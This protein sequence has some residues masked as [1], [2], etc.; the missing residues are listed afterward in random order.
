MKKSLSTTLSFRKNLLVERVH[1]KKSKWSTIFFICSLVATLS[2]YAQTDTLIVRG[3]VENLTLKLYR[4]APEISVARVNILQSNQEIVRAAQLQPDGSFELKMPLIYPQEE[5]YL[6]Y[7]DVVMPF[8]GA[9][10]TVEVTILAD[11]LGKSEVPL[12]FGGLYATTNNRHAQFY[13][14]FNKWLKANP[15][16]PA[17]TDNLHRFWE[18]ASQEQNRRQAFYKSF[19][20][21]KDPLLDKWVISSLENTT[22]AKLYNRHLS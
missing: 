22:K 6:T 18:K 12:Q 3:K 4:Q 5:C 20:S 2:V 13:T 1:N 7:A 17:R 11:S 14:A 19:S 16:K 21:T 9:K 10:G 15:E 8:L